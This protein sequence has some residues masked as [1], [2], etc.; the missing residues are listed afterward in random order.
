GTKFTNIK[1]ICSE[2][3]DFRVQAANG[4][5]LGRGI[6]FSKTSAYSQK[7]AC[8]KKH[9]FV[10]RVLCGQST[11]GNQNLTRPPHNRSGRMF[12]SCVD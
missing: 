3:F 6:Y 10:A 9:M 2:G 5:A 11:C 1:V 12:D 4:S 8:A 7:F